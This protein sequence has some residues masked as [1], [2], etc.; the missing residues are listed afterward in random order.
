MSNVKTLLG[1]ASLFLIGIQTV[2]A[3]VVAYVAGDTLF[4]EGSNANDKVVLTCTKYNLVV[5]DRTNGD[6]YYFSLFKGITRVE[7]NG[8]DGDDYFLYASEL[9]QHLAQLGLPALDCELN[10]GEG[11]DDL[12]AGD[13]ND[14]LDPGEDIAEGMILSGAGRDLFIVS[15]GYRSVRWNKRYILI[16]YEPTYESADFSS[17]DK[18]QEQYYHWH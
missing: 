12:I 9:D 3:D 18:L 6:D 2:S 15:I 17:S 13:G 1:I 16:T 8:N 10:G 7:F 11:Y 4:I 14:V 5:E